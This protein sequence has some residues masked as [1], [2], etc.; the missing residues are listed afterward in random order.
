MAQDH[1]ARLKIGWS[2]GGLIR[3]LSAS[4]FRPKRA[5][6][7]D[8]RR[9]LFSQSCVSLMPYKS[10]HKELVQLSLIRG[11]ARTPQRLLAYCRGN[12][13]VQGATGSLSSHVVTCRPSDVYIGPAPYS[14]PHAI[15][16]PR[17]Y[18][19]V[20]QT[21]YDAATPRSC[22]VSIWYFRENRISVFET[23]DRESWRFVQIHPAD[24]I[25]EPFFWSG[26]KATNV[27]AVCTLLKWKNFFYSC[28]SS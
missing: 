6:L 28:Y 17:G 25:T 7:T 20:Y 24:R 19:D 15:N 16:H 18:M 9:L 4:E 21:N 10:C 22:H 27:C 13:Y 14:T 12:A 23:S 5:K 3:Q 1:S 8:G 2:Y 11:C 26:K